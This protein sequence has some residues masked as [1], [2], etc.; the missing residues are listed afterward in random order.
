L[1]LIMFNHSILKEINIFEGVDT[2]W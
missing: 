2:L 1:C